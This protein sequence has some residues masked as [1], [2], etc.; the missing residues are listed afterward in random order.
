MTKPICN[1]EIALL[2]K[3]T[4]FDMPVRNYYEETVLGVTYEP[5]TSKKPR[6]WNTEENLYSR[7][8]IDTIVRWIEHYNETDV[9][10]GDGTTKE[11]GIINALNI[12][13]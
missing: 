7:P 8:S 10:F 2:A 9:E 11:Q 13:I 1:I 4:G 12:L 3:Q 6:N 5:K